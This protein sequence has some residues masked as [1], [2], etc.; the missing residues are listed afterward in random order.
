MRS[1]GSPAHV[2]RPRPTMDMSGKAGG[3]LNHA[4]SADGHKESA[5]IQG[6]IDSIQVEGHFS[7]PADVGTNLTAAFTPRNFIRRLVETRV[8]ER[9]AAAGIATALEKLSMHVD[10]VSRTCLLVKAVHVLS[11]DEKALSQSK[12][13][14]CEGEVGWIRFGC[15]SN[16]PTHGVELPHQPGI[17]VPSVGRSDLLDPVISPEATH[18][19][20]G[21]NA[22]FRAH[23]CPGE[24]EDAVR[25]GN[26]EKLAI[27]DVSKK[28]SALAGVEGQSNRNPNGGRC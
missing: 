10:D 7:E 3:R 11:A 27:G 6:P 28:T 19:T 20:K 18:A 17:A 25:G 15:R 12:F 23:S 13:K 26:G 9:R 1:Q 16:P 24:N 5:V 8:V 4:R 22:A 14:L 21:W 2:D